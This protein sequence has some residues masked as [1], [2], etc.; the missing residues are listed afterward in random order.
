MGNPGS[1]HDDNATIKYWTDRIGLVQDSNHLEYLLKEVD[2]L[3]LSWQRA[4]PYRRIVHC[5]YI[6]L[7]SHQ[8]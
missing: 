6:T 7:H 8:H 3:T 5:F 4:T 2:M 1:E